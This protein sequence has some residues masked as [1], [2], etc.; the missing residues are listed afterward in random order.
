MAVLTLSGCSTDSDA[1]H[2]DGVVDTVRHLTDGLALPPG[3][4]RVPYDAMHWQIVGGQTP[5]Q[6]GGFTGGNQLGGEGKVYF[7]SDP[8]GGSTAAALAAFD[9]LFAGE[10]FKRVS[11]AGEHSQCKVG[12]VSASW[13]NDDYVVELDY[14]PDA[15]SMIVIPFTYA[16]IDNVHTSSP[17]VQ[18]VTDLPVC[19][20]G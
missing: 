12:I 20:G 1:A 2:R 7:R 15:P 18:V 19:A 3:Y 6:A 8:A 11:Y 13:A 10:G 14:R 4:V 17:P 5:K 16:G 9:R